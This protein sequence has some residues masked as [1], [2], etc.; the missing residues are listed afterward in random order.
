MNKVIALTGRVASGKSTA[1]YAF[2][3]L[4]A[5]FLSLDHLLF[6]FDEEA[7]YNDRQTVSLTEKYIKQFRDNSDDGILVF[8]MSQWVVDELHDLFDLIVVVESDAEL[9]LSRLKNRSPYFTH[10]S[11]VPKFEANIV[12]DNNSDKASLWRQIEDFYNGLL[13]AKTV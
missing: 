12:F 9:R 11:Y 10:D 3:R 6:Y 2:G 8:E 7:G 1:L 5:R 4:G 13:V